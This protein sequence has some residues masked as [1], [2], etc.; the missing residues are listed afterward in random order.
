MV[1]NIIEELQSL[2]YNSCADFRKPASSMLQTIR[3]AFSIKWHCYINPLSLSN[4]HPQIATCML[5]FHQE[6]HEETAK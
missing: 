3:T 2:A 1:G 4:G 6:T 5:R